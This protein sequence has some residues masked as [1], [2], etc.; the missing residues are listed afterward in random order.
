MKMIH[1]IVRLI[2]SLKDTY[3]KKRRK[4]LIQETRGTLENLRKAARQAKREVEK[5][6][7]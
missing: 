6:G 1:L 5:S 2:A 3:Q 7:M 4:R